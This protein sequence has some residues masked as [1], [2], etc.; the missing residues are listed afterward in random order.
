MRL[1]MAAN[2]VA[3]PNERDEKANLEDGGVFWC[4][5]YEK[6]PYGEIDQAGSFKKYLKGDQYK[7]Q[8]EILEGGVASG[9]DKYA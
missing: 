5:P 8:F 6:C 3:M 4:C 2:T 9:G 7:T 1:S